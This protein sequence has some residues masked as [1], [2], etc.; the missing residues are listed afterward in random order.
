MI[1]RWLRGWDERDDR[2]LFKVPDVDPV[3]ELIHVLDEAQE[4]DAA[5][6]RRLYPSVHDGKALS[7]KRRRSTGLRARR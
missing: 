4:R 7:G 1:L 6:E 2:H 5:D 3:D